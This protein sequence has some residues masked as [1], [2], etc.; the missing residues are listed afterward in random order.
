MILISFAQL[1]AHLWTKNC[2]QENRVLCLARQR[3]CVLPFTF[4]LSR[5]LEDFN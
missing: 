1:Y 3:S 4:P 2:G 5:E